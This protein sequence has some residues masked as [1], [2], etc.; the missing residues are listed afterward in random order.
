MTN[1]GKFVHYDLMT[2]DTGR[3]RA[4]YTELLGWTVTEYDMGLGGMYQMLEANGRGFGGIVC[5]DP[6]AGAPSH[7][8]TYISTADL[9]ACCSKAESLGGSVR[10][11][12]TLIPNVGTYAVLE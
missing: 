3:A 5:L 2:T 10:V 9:A 4:F 12:P 11:A 7:W 6:T 1:L 8:I